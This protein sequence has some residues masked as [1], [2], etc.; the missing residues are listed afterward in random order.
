MITRKNQRT[1]RVAF[2][3]VIHGVYFEQFEGL[4]E[5]LNGYHADTVAM[6]EKNQVTVIDYGMV[7]TNQQAFET[8]RKIQADNIDVIFSNMISYATSSVFAPIVQITNAPIVLVA[9]Q[10][11]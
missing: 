1:A 7:Q 4:E 3:S 6:I 10:P 9:L 5:S 11:R 2:F 8:A